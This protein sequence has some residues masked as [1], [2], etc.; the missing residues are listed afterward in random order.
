MKSIL[1]S[2]LEQGSSR[3]IQLV[4]QVLLARLV[5][6]EAFGVLALLLVCVN[7]ADVIAQSGFGSALIQRSKATNK[8]YSTAFWLSMLI[9]L[10]MFVLL[11]LLAPIL[12]A[13]YQEDKLILYLRVVSLIVFFNSAASIQ[14]SYLQSRMDFKRLCIINSISSVFSGVAGVSLAILD[15][16]VWSLIIQAITQS[17]F[18]FLIQLF[19][20]PWRPS[21]EFDKQ[22]AKSMYSYGWKISVTG[23]VGS[24]Y[25]SV[26]ELIVGKAC[27]V[28]DLGFYSQGRKWPNQA[29]AIIS[30]ALQN[31]FFPKFA[32]L[33]TDLTALRDTMKKSLVLG[34][35]LFVPFS[36]LFTVAAEPILVILLTE[37]WLP[38]VPIFQMVCF[39]NSLILLQL[40]NLRA[41]MALGYSEIYMRLEIVKVAIGIVFIGFAAIMSKDIYLVAGVTALVSIFNILVIDLQPA[42]RVHGYSRLSQIKDI[43]PIYLAS[44]FAGMS[45]CIIWF[46]PLSYMLALLCEV[47]IFVT[48]YIIIAFVFRL[49]GARECVAILKKLKKN[50]Y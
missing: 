15:Y 40:I 44:T 24:L 34:S 17:L 30:N 27:S 1:W 42:K 29:L 31:V 7:F 9:A 13:F 47:L 11:W 37:A 2:F 14:R 12:A 3:I 43:G 33:Q 25:T 50:C 23:I 39:S 41:Y 20:V 22:S 45:A 19:L 18:V 49:E 35:F 36:F 8:D 16:G 46:L 4:V 26:S 5:S 10:L 21:L 6:P 32:S 38:C 28:L 48:V